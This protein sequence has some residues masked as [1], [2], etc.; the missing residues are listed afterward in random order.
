MKYEGRTNL[1]DPRLIRVKSWSI[2]AKCP[3][4]RELNISAFK[5]L[6]KRIIFENK[7][8][9]VSVCYPWMSQEFHLI[10]F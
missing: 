10:N 2:A 7:E 6:N 5:L 1:K 3:Q 8:C 4:K 9:M